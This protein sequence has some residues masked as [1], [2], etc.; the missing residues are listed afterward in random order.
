MSEGTHSTSAFHN[1]AWERKSHWKRNV[2][3]LLGGTALAVLAAAVLFQVFRP[4]PSGAG[5][6]HSRAPGQQATGRATVDAPGRAP[7]YLARVNGQLISW[8]LVAGECMERHGPEVLDNIINRTIIQQA[9]EERGLVVTEAEVDA[10]VLRIAQRFNLAVDQWYQLL[11]TEREIT[12]HQYRRD[13]IW[14][15][16]ALKKLAGENVTITDE[17]LKKAYIRDYGDKV[18]AKMILLDNQRRA[19]EAWEQ[20]AKNPD[21][22]GKLVR[23]YSIDPNSRALEGAIPPIRRYSGNDELEKAAFKLKDGEISPVVQVGFDRF[24]ILKCEGR[25][26]GTMGY[27]EVKETLYQHLQEEKVQ[28]AVAHTFEKLKKQSRIDNFLTN[29]STGGI[30]QTSEQRPAPNQSRR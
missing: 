25:I 8:E 7:K 24:V 5:E 23:K 18:K 1:S 26:K 14:P 12:A 21:D 29:T 20:A 10:E 28:E 6:D 2:T 16:L 17:D 11:Q 22:F 30:Q 27:D 4:E 13:V 9:C 15:M 3:F 19:V